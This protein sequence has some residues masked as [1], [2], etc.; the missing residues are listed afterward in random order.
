[1]TALLIA[2]VVF[3]AAVVGFAVST[4]RALDRDDLYGDD[5]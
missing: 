2:I 5:E 4:A 3:V 1:M